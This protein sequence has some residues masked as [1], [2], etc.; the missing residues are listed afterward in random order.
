MNQI[1]PELASTAFNHAV[2][3]ILKVDVIAILTIIKIRQDSVCIT[4]IVM[5][6]HCLRANAHIVPKNK[7]F[8]PFYKNYVNKHFCSFHEKYAN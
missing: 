7:H 4:Q 8:C 1:A 5:W 3:K 6:N 2:R